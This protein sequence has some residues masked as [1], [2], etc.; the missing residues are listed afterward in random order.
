MTYIVFFEVA[1]FFETHL[2]QIKPCIIFLEKG[3]NVNFSKVPYGDI[4]SQFGLDPLL[5]GADMKTF[6][7]H[8]AR[9][10]TSMFKAIMEDVSVIMEQ[11]GE[12]VG[13]QNAEARSRYLAPVSAQRFPLFLLCL[14]VLE[15]MFLSAV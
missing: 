6:E 13:D 11:Y 4:A 5:E 10:P 2:Q 8:R 12:R 14:F 9:I 1:L 7:I 15:L 3:L